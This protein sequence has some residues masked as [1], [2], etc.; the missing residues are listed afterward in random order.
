MLAEMF[1]EDPH[2]SHV[3]RAAADG[4]EGKC[5]ALAAWLWAF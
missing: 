1:F 2:P 3:A 5:A 4:V